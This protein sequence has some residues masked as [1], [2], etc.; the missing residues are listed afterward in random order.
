VPA[1]ED[2]ECPEYVIRPFERPWMPQPAA[3]QP[4]RMR[5]K[6]KAWH[7]KKAQ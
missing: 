7:P 5:Q 3:F 4:S 6:G 1:A 2:F